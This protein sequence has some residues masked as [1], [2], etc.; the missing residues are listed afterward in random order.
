MSIQNSESKSSPSLLAWIGGFF[1]LLVLMGPLLAI[2]G[3]AIHLLWSWFVVPLGVP[4]ISVAHAAGLSLLMVFVRGVKTGPSKAN[5]FKQI[6]SALSVW[7]ICVLFG[8]F[9]HL[10]LMG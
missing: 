9:I 3:L 2:G 7:G 4:A 1:A 5:L 10:F 6:L 8:F